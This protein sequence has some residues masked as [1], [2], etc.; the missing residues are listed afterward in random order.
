MHGV[1]EPQVTEHGPLAAATNLDHERWAH[2][3]FRDRADDQAERARELERRTLAE[4]LHAR[5]ERQ[6]AERLEARVAERD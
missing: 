6:A 3:R 2:L 1:D 4:R 5:A